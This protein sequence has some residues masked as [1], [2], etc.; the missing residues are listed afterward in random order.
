MVLFAGLRVLRT[1]AFTR[2]F[3]SE[4]AYFRIACFACSLV[5]RA[6]S[7]AAV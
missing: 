5:K 3:D 4:A 1:R 2:R 6:S 7:I